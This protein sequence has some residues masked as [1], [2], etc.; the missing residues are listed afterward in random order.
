VSAGSLLREGSGLYEDNKRPDFMQT[1]GESLHIY[2]CATVPDLHRS[3]LTYPQ[4]LLCFSCIVWNDESKVKL[5]MN[6][7]CS[8]SS[9]IS[10]HCAFEAKRAI[11][12]PQ[13]ASLS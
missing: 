1:N 13:K 8:Q 6:R 11:L 4:Y 12:L 5:R 7:E 10:A 2:S 3:S 9:L